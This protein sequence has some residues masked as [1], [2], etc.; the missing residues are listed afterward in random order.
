MEQ[1]IERILTLWEPWASAIRLGYKSVETRSW[2]TS[3]R[4][5]LWIHAAR[6]APD[7][8]HLEQVNDALFA[9]GFGPL[10]WSLP[11]GKV[12]ARAVLVDCVP[13]RPESSLWPDPVDCSRTLERALGNYE[14]GRWAWV[15]DDIRGLVE[16]AGYRGGQGLRTLAAEDLERLRAAEQLPTTELRV[17]LG[18]VR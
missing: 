14:P 4:G 17:R 15:L 6:A 16:P 10:P 7:P 3:Y 12:V 2:H 18:G 5:P 13:T 1:A 11:S 9:A 8:D